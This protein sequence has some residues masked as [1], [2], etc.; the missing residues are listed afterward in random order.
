MTKKQQFKNEQ[1]FAHIGLILIVIVILAVGAVGYRVWHKGHADQKPAGYHAAQVVQNG[2]T[3]LSDSNSLDPLTKG[4]SLSNGQCSGQGSKPLTHAPMDMK[5]VDNIQP[6]GLMVGGHVTPVDHEYYYQIN[7]N[8]APN[9]YP[10]YADADGSIVG[11]QFVND[12]TKDAWWMTI[13]H[14]CTFISNYN[15]MTSISADIKAKLPNGWGPN[16]N[17]GINIPVKSGDLIGY[18]GHQSL[19]YQVW[20]TEKT[21]KGLLHPVAYNNGEAWKVNT[22]APLDYFTSSVKAQILPKYI[23]RTS[24]PLDGKIDYDVDGEAVGTWFLKGTNGYAGN[25]S[26]GTSGYWSGHLA[27]AYFYLDPS[28]LEF[29]IG[30]YQGQATQFAVVGNSP[31]WKTITPSSGVVKYQLGQMQLVDSAGNTWTGRYAKSVT[32]HAGAAQATV[33]LQMTAK[34]EMKLEVF[35]GKTPSQVSGFDSNVRTYDRGQD[36]HMVTSTTAH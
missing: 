1:G 19:D 11:V 17:G 33:L 16:S 6:M 20:N 36:A 28:V 13:A 23:N 22:V 26:P 4:K 25:A 31:D 35:P 7:P 8:A 14:T 32:A 12:G 34:Q 21:L 10:V 5:D 9:T 2:D 18:V 3:R 30:D 15:L 24:G 27:L 29:S